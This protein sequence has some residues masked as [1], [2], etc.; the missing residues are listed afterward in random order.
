[1]FPR[2][3]GGS[4]QRDGVKGIVVHSVPHLKEHHG[5]RSKSQVGGNSKHGGC[6]RTW[7]HEENRLSSEA[8]F[9]GVVF[10]RQLGKYTV[11]FATGDWKTL[12]MGM[13]LAVRSSS[14][15]IPACRGSAQTS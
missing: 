2:V 13:M 5:S 11:C 6:G 4:P 1:M 7:G 15:Y 14:A 12:A 3:E 10:V 8:N 9:A